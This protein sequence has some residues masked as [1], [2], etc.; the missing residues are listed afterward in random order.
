TK[1]SRED[2]EPD[3]SRKSPKYNPQISE[4]LINLIL[5]KM[6]PS[7]KTHAQESWESYVASDGISVQLPSTWV[8]T[9]N[10]KELQP[11]PRDQFSH[12]KNNLIPGQKVQ[13]PDLGQIPKEFQLY[14][15]SQNL[16]I[17]DQMIKLWDE[18]KSPQ[19][20]AY[21]R[22]LSGPMGIGKSY[23]SYFLAARTYAEGWLTLYIAD[24]EKLDKDTR[25]ESEFEVVRRFLTLN[26]DIL[27]SAD[28]SML[29]TAYHEPGGELMTLIFERFLLQ[30]SN[31]RRALTIVDEHG[32]LFRTAPY[33]P[34]KYLSLKFLD[35]LPLWTD[36]YRGSCVLF[37]GTAHA[38]YEMTEMESSC[39]SDQLTVEFVSPLTRDTFLDLVSDFVVNITN[40]VPR[41]LMQ[42]SLHI[43]QNPGQL[44]NKALSVFRDKRTEVFKKDAKK[45][46]DRVKSDNVAYRIFYRGLAQAFLHGSVEEDFKWDFIDLGLLYRQRREGRILFCPLCPATKKA[47][48]ELFKDMSLPEL[49]RKRLNA[50]QLDGK[51]FEAVFFHAVIIA[52]KPVSLKATNLVGDCETFVK[53]D[54]KDYDVISRG[55]VHSLGV[56]EEEYL[57]RGYNNY[58]RF[59]FMVG[60]ILIQVSVSEFGEHNKKKSSADLR[61]AFKR[62]YKDAFKRAHAKNQI[63]CYLDHLYGGDHTANMDEETGKFVVTKKDEESKEIPVDGFRIVYICGRDI[64]LK[65]HSGLIKEFAD[66]KHVS[67]EELKDVLFRNIFQLEDL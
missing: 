24:A 29:A 53:L 39:R 40:C 57:A 56:G 14:N 2:D 31:E 66:V 5:Q 13:V 42:M 60:S 6:Q 22:V 7:E 49:F 38:K 4:S 1:R 61:N 62:P 41:E 33:V 8:K 52:D 25:K 26:K 17:T 34:R 28:L 9:L 19:R 37:T 16:L 3:T 47:L 35:R 44:I 20:I 43:Q 12:L 58:P 15:E 50:G 27:T 46:L 51:E 23:L 30:K 10:S 63:E 54:F 64:N 21:R 59:D 67:F 55:D 11:A 32:A 45:Y 18:M 65:N 48:L 36:N